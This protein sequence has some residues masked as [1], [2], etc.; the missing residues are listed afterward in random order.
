[1]VVKIEIKIDNRSVTVE[2]N[3]NNVSLDNLFEIF[4]L[5]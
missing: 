1:M 3:V 2:E 5:N 4:S